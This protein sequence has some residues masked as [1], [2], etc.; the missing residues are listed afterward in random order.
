MIEHIINFCKKWTLPVAITVGTAVYFI[1]ASIPGF[2]A[3]GEWFVG[4][5]GMALPAALFMVLFVTFCRIDFRKMRLHW[6]HF[7][8]L[9]TQLVMAC[10]I[11]ATIHFMHLTGNELVL[12][13]CMLTCIIGPCAAASAVVTGKLGGD[14]ESMTTFTFLSNFATAV[15]IPTLFPL[16]NPS[17][18]ISFLSA[19]MLILYKV[20]IVLV[21]PMGC[22]WVVKHYL[23]RLHQWMTTKPDLSFYLW[24]CVLAMVT[25]TTMRNI[26]HASTTW[27][28]LSVIAALSLVLCFVQFALGRSIGN[29]FGHR[30]DCGQALG[31]KNTAFAIWI[32]A[33]YLQPLASVA[34]GCYILWQNIVNSFELWLQA[35]EKA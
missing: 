4:A 14:V 20:L 24:A 31:Q 12:M 10:G 9:V 27:Q 34:P 21:L 33:A 29:T 28:M 32:S 1:F 6:W 13:E 35:R 30:I 5:F 26:V 19:F 22:A 7:W 23:H 3:C 15:L 8:A 18:G 16:V 11:V 25:G 2:D 17:A